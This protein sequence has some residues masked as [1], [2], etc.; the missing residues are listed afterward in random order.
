[1]KTICYLLCV[2][3]R[4]F[5]IDARVDTLQMCYLN[6]YE[7]EIC[8]ST[9]PRCMSKEPVANTSHNV[10]LSLLGEIESLC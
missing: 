10:E 1:M 9:P 7:L 6:P 4:I 3:T 5:S 8:K 2:V